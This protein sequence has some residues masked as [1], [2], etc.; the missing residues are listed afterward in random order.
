[1]IAAGLDGPSE[2]REENLEVGA[3]LDPVP[4]GR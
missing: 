2:V 4:D 3:I 1:M